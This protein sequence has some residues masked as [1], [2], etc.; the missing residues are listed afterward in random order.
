LWTE[1]PC[2]DADERVVNTRV[3]LLPDIDGKPFQRIQRFKRSA[4]G[5]L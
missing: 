1:T 3:E 5:A 4:I 2:Y